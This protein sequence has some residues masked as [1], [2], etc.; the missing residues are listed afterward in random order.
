MFYINFIYRK[1]HYN[2]LLINNI[3]SYAKEF[4][5]SQKLIFKKL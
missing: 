1:N 3:I 5:G 2:I 4:K